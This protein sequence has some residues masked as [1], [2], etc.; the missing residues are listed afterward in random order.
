MAV[1]IKAFQE[2]YPSTQVGYLRTPDAT[3]RAIF[4]VAPKQTLPYANCKDC[5]HHMA[6][7][8]E[9][10]SHERHRTVP[11]QE[12]LTRIPGYPSKLVIFKIPASSYWWVRYYANQRI[13]KRTT[14]TEVKRDALEA[15]KRFYDDINLRLHNGSIDA[16]LDYNPAQVMTFA[17][18][19]RLLIESEEGKYK[20]GQLTKIS[21]ENMQLRLNKHVLPFFGQ[22]DVNMINY[23]M[24][25]SFLQHLSGAGN[26]LS[27]ST[28]SAYMGLVRK[29]LI[30]AAR[31]S[32]IKHVPEFPNVGV[33]DKPRG[34]FTVPEYKLI[35]SKAKKLADQTVEWRKDAL[36]GESYF[37]M[38]GEARRGD[39]KMVRRVYMTR[40]LADLIVFMVNSYIRPTDV[41]NMQHGHVHV[42]DKEYTYLRLALPPS[43]GHSFPITTMPWAV[44]VYE[45]LCGRR[46]KEQGSEAA[47]PANEYVFMPDAPSREDA[48]KKLQRQFEVV[49]DMTGL[50][51]SNTGEIRSLYSLR[52]SSIMFRLL[53]GRAIDTLTLARN[54]RT[55]PEMIDRFYAAPLQ[56]EMNI[57]MLQSR[58]NPRPWE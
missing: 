20:R 22:V 11:L 46:L 6:R 35:T 31:H 39:D 16:P 34:W 32:F 54:A 51:Y 41:K 5:E 25:D 30:H 13:F 38:P 28:I 17:G 49:L 53:Y 40:D 33:E 2:Q 12:T 3:A 29:V 1:L 27:V 57:E 14:K 55:S 18:A 48:M 19:A 44:R 10:D 45:R 24:L 9:P 50:R 8:L 23:K 37:C 42:I 7:A 26:G 58:R 4:P 15:A 36:T 21:F 43:K 52:H 56:G 47:L